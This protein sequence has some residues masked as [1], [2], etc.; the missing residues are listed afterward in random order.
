MISSTWHRVWK[1]ALETEGMT[2]AHSTASGALLTSRIMSRA[3]SYPW[4]WPVVTLILCLLV[5]APNIAAS[6]SLFAV[7]SYVVVDDDDAL[8]D[9]TCRMQDLRD[10]N[11]LQ[12]HAIL[13]AL[14]ATPFFRTFHVDLEAP[15]PL[16]Q[17]QVEEVHE[18]TSDED[19]VVPLCTV[20]NTENDW[21][22][23]NALSSL[24]H[25]GFQ[26]T[27]QHDAFSWSTSTDQVVLSDDCE[28]SFWTDLCLQ[29]ASAKAVNLQLN[30]ERNTAYNGTHIWQAIYQENCVLDEHEDMCLEERVLYRLL[31]GL[32]TSTTLSIASAYYA[33]SA[34]K[35]RTE[36]QSNPEYFM[37]KMAHHP[38]YIRNLH[39]TYA[40]LLRALLKAQPL[41]ERTLID[42]GDALQDETTRVLLKRLV[43]S[44]VLESCQHAFTAFD[45]TLLFQDASAALKHSFKDVFRNVSSI[46]D[47]V[48][49]QQCKLHGK[50]SMLGLGT[51][52]RVLLQT[53]L[54]DLESNQVVALINTVAKFSHSL[55]QVRQLTQEYWGQHQQQ[56]QVS[57]V[58]VDMDGAV[59]TI[60]RLQLPWPQE[61]ALVQLA[62][63]RDEAI[64]V[65]TKHYAQDAGKFQ[66]LALGLIAV[67][68]DV[69]PDAIVVGSGLAG[70]AA[71]LRLL[72]RGGSVVILEKEHLLGGN[73]NKASSGINAHVTNVTDSHDLFVHD[74]TKSAGS[75]AR[76]DLIETLIS[77]SAEA[78]TWLQERVGVD[79][80]LK[81]QLGGHSSQRTHRPSN[82][83][84]GAEIIYGIQRAVKEYVKSGRVEIWTDTKVTRLLTSEV[85]AVTGVA[86]EKANGEKGE[87]QTPNTV[88]ATGGFAA[89]RS[90]GSY[91][92][93]YRP[94][95]LKMPTTAGEFSTGDGVTLATA[96]GAGITDMDKI[97]V[98]PTGWVD[99]KDPDNRSKI[100]AAE[101]MR[102]VGG[103]LI[104]SQGE[105]FCN[106]LGT[107]A[108]VTDRM[109]SHDDG[110]RTSRKWSIETP[111]P[112]F[113]LVLSSSAAQDAQK[114]VDLY[115][116]KGLL[117]RFEG[118]TALA[119]WMGL[120]KDVVETTL[121]EYQSAATTGEDK[122]NK[123]T[124]RGVPAQD[125]ESDIFFA[126]TITPVLHYCMGGVTIDTQ[127]NVLDT[128]GQPIVGLHGAG[129]V[130]GG[131]HGVNRLAGNSLLECTVYG[132][133]VGNKLPVQPR[134]SLQA[135]SP[136]S[137]TAESKKE[138][139]AVSKA[140]L[141]SHN[142]DGDCW[143]AIH[144]VV[145]DLTEFAEEHPAGPLS[146]REL[147]GQDG[148]EAFAAVHN[149]RLLDDFAEDRIGVLDLS[150]DTSLSGG[151]FDDEFECEE[152]CSVNTNPF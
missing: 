39:F 100:L 99:P 68:D 138:D 19:D 17:Q 76:P 63:R 79:L 44:A 64:L 54:P 40:V 109:L 139:K 61:R 142:T 32:H 131:V 18:C 6:E 81:A 49:C 52:L 45:E 43:D 144:G 74:T 50:L 122:Y 115:S 73:S 13:E 66:E 92:E 3:P 11:D 33:P 93:Q 83:M 41:L 114:H 146:I 48:Q 94:E 7:P 113:S 103:L 72:D 46:L 132:S 10:A 152:K 24:S 42:T 97:Q 89:D 8:E 71:A 141:E 28:A 147:A 56:Q 30:P 140:E 134:E 59:S 57:S 35:N 9:V 117:H 77:H 111:V 4:R 16:Q 84:A 27:A 36:W 148:T 118:L 14:T 124:F 15:C 75:A 120:P 112:Q 105:R 82:G 21:I 95:L 119:R 108:Y 101:L 102:G 137:S 67:Q 53:T 69:P 151:S 133:I 143:V 47:C 78:V 29:D 127:G 150:A 23:S 135:A 70:L 90:A 98:H 5:Y 107:R 123:T 106:E 87:L 58:T 96:L 1:L 136:I 22:H 26:S 128:S 38:E 126:G 51:A 91:L 86:Y 149:E 55:R 20:D 85:G 116:H 60:T 145:Y 88:L 121:R 104:N 37:E 12:L 110:Y 25:D 125:L 62:L 2:R 65:L 31:S 130:T 129:E 80:S 34:R